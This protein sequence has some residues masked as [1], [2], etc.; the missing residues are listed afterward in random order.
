VAW[1]LSRGT[2]LVPVLGARNLASVKDL[3]AGANVE[4]RLEEWAELERLVP[5]DQVRG[6]RYPPEQ[7]RMVHR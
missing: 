5:H 1:I 3:I 6:E 4:L 7:M 2:D